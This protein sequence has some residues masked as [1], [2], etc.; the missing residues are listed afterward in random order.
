MRLHNKGPAC[1]R[2]ARGSVRRSCIPA[3]YLKKR[4]ANYRPPPSAGHRLPHRRKAPTNSPSTQGLT[5]VPVRP[6]QSPACSASRWEAGEAKAIDDKVIK[7][8]KKTAVMILR[9]IS[10]I[11]L[12]ASRRAD[13]TAA[14]R[15]MATMLAN[16]P[17]RVLEGLADFLDVLALVAAGTA[18]QRKCL[19]VTPNCRLK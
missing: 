4:V 9:F 2:G 15:L 1:C 17:Q 13:D 10:R 8:P 3:Q 14:T 5:P 19:G 18:V 7:A 12:V 16:D 11:L 6:L